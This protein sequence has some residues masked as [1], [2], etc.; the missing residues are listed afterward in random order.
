MK[1]ENYTF[2]SRAF[3]VNMSGEVSI[4]LIA[5]RSRTRGGSR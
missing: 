1:T 4:P 5:G 3:V 2:K